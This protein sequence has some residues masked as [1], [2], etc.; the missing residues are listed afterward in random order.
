MEAPDEAS[1][2][3]PLCEGPMYGWIS[4]PRESAQASVGM[5]VAEEDATVVDRCE[6]CGAGLVR[7]PAP[8]DLGAELSALVDRER[9]VLVAANRGSVQASIGGD[10]WA[11]LVELP[12]RLIH[13]RRSLELIAD[14]EGHEITEPGSPPVGRGQRWMWQTLVNGLTLQPNFFFRARRG[15]LRPTTGRGRAAFAID[16]VVTLLA[17][18]LVA[19]LSVP[20]ELVSALIGRGG[21]LEARLEDSR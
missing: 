19:L 2:R 7:D 1:V 11:A 5:P 6:D 17:A 16:A 8:V 10:G 13:T 15:G 20:L 18:P 12:T 21:V 4:V 3:C 9:G 14:R